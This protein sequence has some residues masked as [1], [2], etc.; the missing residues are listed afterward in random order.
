[1]QGWREDDEKRDQ[2][3]RREGQA[4]EKDVYKYREEEN[5]KKKR[6]RVFL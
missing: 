1:M 2:N 6:E 3:A 4:V 5:K